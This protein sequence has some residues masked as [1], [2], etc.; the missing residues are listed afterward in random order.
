MSSVSCSIIEMFS[1]KT[2]FWIINVTVE[3]RIF[4]GRFESEDF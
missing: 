3:A 2:L 4:K 1:I